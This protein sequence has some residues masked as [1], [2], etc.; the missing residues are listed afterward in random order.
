M[1]K[2]NCSSCN[3]EVQTTRKNQHLCSKPICRSRHYGKNRTVKYGEGGTREAQW[4]YDL[5]LKYGL[6]PQEYTA[7]I[8]DA[9][10]KCEICFETLEVETHDLDRFGGKYYRPKKGRI[11][12]ATPCVD[13][14]HSTG[15]VRGILC[16]LCNKALGLLKDD[17]E[18]LDAAKIYLNKGA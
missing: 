9:D 13:H 6:T 17:P 2:F 12:G 10:F 8:E 18:R 5:R 15:N 3:E 7:L 11:N 16:G 14:C 1:R 4:K